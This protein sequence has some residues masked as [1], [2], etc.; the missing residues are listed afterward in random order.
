[1]WRHEIFP[2]FFPRA[3]LLSEDAQFPGKVNDRSKTLVS[4][5]CINRFACD[6]YKPISK[7]EHLLK[8]FDRPA[9]ATIRRSALHPSLWAP[10][11][12][13]RFTDEQSLRKPPIT[14]ALRAIPRA[15]ARPISGALCRKV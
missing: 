3:V 9:T 15:G 1:M 8:I 12:P 2:G 11:R 5:I 6:H 13:S 7:S 10:R 4:E 14:F